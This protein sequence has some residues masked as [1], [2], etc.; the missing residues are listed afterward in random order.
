MLIPA[1]T[2]A[3][4]VRALRV[5]ADPDNLPY[6]ND[7]LEGFENRIA[8]IVA[9][10]LNADLQY[11]WYPQRRGFIRKTLKAG[12]CD[13]VIGVPRGYDPVL[14]TRPYY[15][16]SYVFVSAKN[17][18]L[19][20]RSFD[21]P[22]L[23]DLRIGLQAF[24]DDGANSPAAYA[25]VRRGII[26]NIVGFPLTAT[27]DSP[28]GRIIDAVRSGEIDVAIVWGPFAGYFARTQR[29]YLEVTPVLPG[30]AGASIPFV[31][32]VSMG[33]RPGDKQFR[34]ELEGVLERRRDAIHGILDSYGVPLSGSR[35]TT[36]A[37]MTESSSALSQSSVRKGR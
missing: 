20:L 26:K 10:E 6:S 7:R 22:V 3:D 37:S 35:T 15:S 30:K 34:D 5:C 28:A 21:D 2:A 9:K 23:S 11:T 36:S 24:G 4:S 25:L 29:N 14:T 27:A 19:G 17:R 8:E 32:D 12:K 18:R 13:V 31:Y 16:S 1:A 33:V